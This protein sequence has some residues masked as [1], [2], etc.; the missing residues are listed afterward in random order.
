M[1]TKTGQVV[2]DKMDKTIVV[3]VTYSL[4]HPIYQKSYQQTKKFYAHDPENQY[5]E[6]D[7]VTIYEDV[8]RSKKKRWT[9]V[10]PEKK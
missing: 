1:R 2:S 7:S 4:I 10:P 8:P 3:E 9:V 6:G 5:K